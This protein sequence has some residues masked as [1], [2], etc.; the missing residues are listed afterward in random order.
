MLLLTSS[1][2]SIVYAQMGDTPWDWAAVMLP[3]AFAATLAGQVG[4][5]VYVSMCAG[6]CD[7]CSRGDGCHAADGLCSNTGR[8]GGSAVVPVFGAGVSSDA[9]RSQVTFCSEHCYCCTVA[10]L[11]L[12]LLVPHRLR[13]TG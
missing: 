13:L 3:M 1:A 2:S 5:G 6:G 8:T 12:L 11:L 9:A 7:V 10:L 4:L